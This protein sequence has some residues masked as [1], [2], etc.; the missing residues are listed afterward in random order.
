MKAEDTVM[1]YEQKRKLDEDIEQEYK[2]KMNYKGHDW[3]YTDNDRR[4]L[5]VQMEWRGL[6]KQA[7]I[8][9]KA[10]IKEVVE[11]MKLHKAYIEFQ[12]TDINERKLLHKELQD[13]LKSKGVEQANKEAYEEAVREEHFDKTNSSLRQEFPKRRE[14]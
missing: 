6:K 10:G 12:E 1:T 9:F 3:R 4:T 5:E 11:W 2:K 14:R 13:F 8:S 7:K